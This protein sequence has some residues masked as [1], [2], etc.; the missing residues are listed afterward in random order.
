MAK[1]EARPAVLPETPEAS[2]SPSCLGP[3]LV[4]VGQITA[5]EDLTIRGGFQGTL[6]MGRRSLRIEAG[7]RVESE[8]EAGSVFVRGTLSGNIRASGAV[9][10]APEAVVKGDIVAAK[11]TIRE[12]A[13]F[14]G[15]IRIVTG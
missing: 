5:D 9:A 1:N 7:A 15:G 13:Q 11:V 10:L 14:R 4:C 12:G 3:G 2:S 8:I 6:K